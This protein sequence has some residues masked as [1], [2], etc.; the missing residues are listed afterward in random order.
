MENW[1]VWDGNFTA[2]RTLSETETLAAHVHFTNLQDGE[3]LFNCRFLRNA[4]PIGCLDIRV[5]LSDEDKVYEQ[6]PRL[7]EEFCKKQERE[8][9]GF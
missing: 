8:K 7:W 3:W 9:A 1:S 6:L 4:E 2:T 5:E